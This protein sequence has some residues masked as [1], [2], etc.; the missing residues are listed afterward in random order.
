MEQA[1]RV[2]ESQLRIGQAYAALGNQGKAE[3]YYRATVATF[4]TKGLKPGDDAADYPSEAQFLLA[5]RSLR[6]VSETKLRS[7]AAKKLEKE[8]KALIDNLIAATSEFDKVQDYNRVEWALAA[9]YS[10]GRA[11]EQTAIN[12]N[13]APVPAKLKQ[14]SE[15]WFA[16]KDIVGQAAQAAE[17]KA[18]AEYEATLQLARHYRVENEWTRAARERLNIYKPQEYPL[19]RPPALDMQVGGLR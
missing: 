11:L 15:A 19:L 13:D 4:A 14:H 10:K 1:E 17:A 16:Y 12:I 18:L 2:V 6:Q 9:T 7:T 8:T 5:T 3:E